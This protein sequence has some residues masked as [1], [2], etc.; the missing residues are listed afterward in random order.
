VNPGRVVVVG[1]SNTDMVVRTPR[2]PARGETVLGG[3]FASLAGGKGANQAIAAA[4][5]G[6]AVVFVG[7]VGEDALGEAAVAGLARDG[8]DTRFVTR[9]PD[10]ASG[11]ALIVVDAEGENLIAVAPGANERLTSAHVDAAAA[12]IEAADVLLAQ[13]EVP[14]PAVTRAVAIA[15]AAGK[16]VVLNP[17]PAQPLPPSLL[18]Q[19]DFLTPNATEAALLLDDQGSSSPEELGAALLTQGPGCAIVTLGRAGVLVAGPGET[20]RWPAPAVQ[21]V[22]TTAA[23]DAFSGAL[24]AALA[25]GQDLPAAVAFGLAAAAIS[26]TRPGAQAS[27]PGREEVER[28][29]RASPNA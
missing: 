23:G 9:D 29:L 27:M 15:R 21:A 24:A 1:S 6:A 10:A 2:L 28:V 17:A 25:E 3:G 26:V 7:C 11:V 16:R 20:C 22:D 8:I 12:A 18:R 19:V 4:R 5:L 14:L 13:L